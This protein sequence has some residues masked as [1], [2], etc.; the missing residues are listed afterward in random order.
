MAVIPSRPLRDLRFGPTEKWM[1][2][3]FGAVLDNPADSKNPFVECILTHCRPNDQ[4]PRG[5]SRSISRQL[6]AH[7]D[8]CSLAALEL[9]REYSDGVL[10]KLSFSGLPAEER[11]TFRFHPEAASEA[12]LNDLGLA[13]PVHPLG[14][15]PSRHVDSAVKLVDGDLL[16][17]SAISDISPANAR[18]MRIVIS[19]ME[20]IRF[21]CAMSEKLA[22]AAFN[23]WFEKGNLERILLTK[24]EQPHLYVDTNGLR[25]ARLEHRHGF[26]A[27]EVAIIGRTL[28]SNAADRGMRRIFRS[29]AA[30]RLSAEAPKRDS[31]NRYHVRT[32]FP[33]DEVAYLQLAGRR[34]KV[35]NG[36]FVFLAYRII[37]CS[38]SFP[39][40]VLSY[41]SEMQPGGAPAPEGA[42]EVGIGGPRFLAGG[43]SDKGEVV[44]NEKARAFSNE[45]SSTA[46]GRRMVSLDRV[47][48]RVE[49][50]RPNTH[51][52]RKDIPAPDDGPM[53]RNSNA[54]STTTGKT[55]AQRQRLTDQIDAGPLPA[56][57]E[58]F[59]QVLTFLQ[60][61]TGWHVDTVPI[62]DE[63]YDA[64]LNVIFNSF[65][66]VPC[67]VKKMRMRQFSF[68]DSARTVSRRLL[69]ASVRVG[70]EVA[71]VLEA[72]RREK[73]GKYMDDLPVLVICKPRGA[74]I[75]Q[76]TLRALLIKT[77]M[78]PSK[79]WPA[80]LSDFRLARKAV[81]HVR[82]TGGDICAA[83]SELARR[84]QLAISNLLSQ[85]SP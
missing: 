45:A 75:A 29:F 26:N 82:A 67:P 5:F 52:A 58:G 73:D 7:V 15:L 60:A 56:D 78:N 84:I 68:M 23:G 22:M 30:Q 12:F 18:P 39:F 61:S 83:Q 49:K 25:I 20:L 50:R 33:F 42:P 11:I 27:S 69:C 16:R 41:Q 66:Q 36:S 55:T 53:L 43:T 31:P 63:W 54:G 28:F 70:A 4:S 3:W 85:S 13:A 9:G 64:A 48:L 46:E 51:V 24:H 6:V 77:V 44:S 65:P 1:L 21:Y 81:E 35:E 72:Q 74:P 34:A 57:L 59:V 38:G 76:E 79:T 14:H 10:Q 32:L 2:E 37:S 80:D 47:E 8:V 17:S 62:H 19:E 40:D 71:Y